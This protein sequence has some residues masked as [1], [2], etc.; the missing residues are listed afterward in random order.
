MTATQPELDVVQQLADRAEITDLVSRLG[1]WLDEK[2]FD[3]AT[4]VLTDDATVKT[5]GGAAEGIERVIAQARRTHEIAETQHVIT[6]A[7]VDLD[8]DRA[9]VRANLVVTFVH[10]EERSLFTLGEV[11]RFQA[12]RTPAGWRLAG[13]EVAPVWERGTRPQPA[14]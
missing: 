2:R 13:I 8:G 9:S 11:Y 4:E 3:E 12:V 14:S 6:N 7:L 10:G 5:P 1:R